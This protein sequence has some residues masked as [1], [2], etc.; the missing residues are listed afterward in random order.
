MSIHE[1]QP[2]VD[3]GSWT[4]GGPRLLSCVSALYMHAVLKHWLQATLHEGC[5]TG[6]PGQQGF[7]Q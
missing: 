3:Q 1:L 7:Y 2:V 6:A 4:C 5:V